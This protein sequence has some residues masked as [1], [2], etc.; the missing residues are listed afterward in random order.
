MMKNFTKRIIIV[1]SYINYGGPI[2]LAELCRNL[3][4]MGYDAR[5]LMVPYFPNKI[6]DQAGYKRYIIKFQFIV[7][8]NYIMSRLTGKER[9]DRFGRTYF[10]SHVKGCKIKHL[11]YFKKKNSIVIYPEVVFGNPLGAENVVRWLLFTT[12][13][14]GVPNAYSSTDLFIAYRTI[15]NDEE[16][17]PNKYILYQPFFDLELYKR[18]NYGHRKGKCFIIRK[19]ANRHDLPYTFDGPVIDN[20]PE[21]DKVRLFNEC[22][23]CYSYDTQTAYSSIAAI[24]GCKVVVV[25]EPGKS[26]KDYLKDG[27][28]GYGIAYGETKEE[29]EWASFT[30]DKLIKFMDKSSANLKNAESF[31]EL[32]KHKFG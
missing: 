31:I 13:Y 4:K 3:L 5:L 14:K 28:V 17:N 24:C 29:M 22:E 15:F 27:D 11:P 21:K 25:P 32:L 1:N 10:F 2:V 26:R 30:V 7:L 9:K 23:Y 8:F 20:L 12:K 18:Y 6:V 19:G 16:L